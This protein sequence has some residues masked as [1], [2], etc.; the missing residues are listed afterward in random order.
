MARL[1]YI[2]LAQED[3]HKLTT[4]SEKFLQGMKPVNR[5]EI[6]IL[7]FEIIIRK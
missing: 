5:R 2:D 6:G 1:I 4:V 7:P 3:V